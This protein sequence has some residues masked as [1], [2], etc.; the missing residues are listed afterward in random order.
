MTHQD[1]LLRPVGT[2][3]TL[4]SASSTQF[5]P[6]STIPDSKLT[7]DVFLVASKVNG[8]HASDL[9]LGRASDSRASGSSHKLTSSSD[10][11]ALLDSR[12]DQLAGNWCAEGL[13]EGS[14]GHFEGL[15]CEGRCVW[16]QIGERK[17]VSGFEVWRWSKLNFLVETDLT[18]FGQVH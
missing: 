17:R 13:G 5:I 2:L 3:C 8:L 11:C 16:E 6:D 15:N 14:R 10:K 1:L 12:G 9:L 7:I 18:D 4:L